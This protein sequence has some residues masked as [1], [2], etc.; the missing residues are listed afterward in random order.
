METIKLR[1]SSESTPVDPATRTFSLQYTL[2]PIEYPLHRI[3]L[4]DKSCS[5]SRTY[6][7]DY[8]G[9]KALYKLHLYDILNAAFDVLNIGPD[10]FNIVIVE[11]SYYE[12]PSIIF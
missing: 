10:A 1:L 6:S 9:N 4:F 7:C 2:K 5:L 8:S 3:D 11:G 12:P